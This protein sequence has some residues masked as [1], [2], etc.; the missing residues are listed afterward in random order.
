L[1]RTWTQ[2]LED[3][4]SIAETRREE[5]WEAFTF[6]TAHTAPISRDDGDD[7]ERFG[8][9]SVLPDNYAEE[10]TEA[11]ENHDFDEYQVFDT[12]VEGFKYLV[13]EMVDADSRTSL[14]LAQRYD[15][16]L[17]PAMVAS[18]F[19][20]EMMYTRVKQ[21]DGTELA[22]FEHPEYEPL[23]PDN[24]PEGDQSPQP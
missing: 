8:L 21:I 6:V 20:E 3:M 4:E 17:A 7:P 12:E 11:V 9:I 14:M 13:T 23:L 15:L 1:T 24:I 18:A 10:F 22:V 5:G 19:D 2:T 16:M